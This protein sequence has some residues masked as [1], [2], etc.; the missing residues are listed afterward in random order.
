MSENFFL[1]ADFL[2]DTHNLETITGTTVSFHIK[3]SHLQPLFTKV[4][5]LL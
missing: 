2:E 1:F 4:Y 3:I 5:I